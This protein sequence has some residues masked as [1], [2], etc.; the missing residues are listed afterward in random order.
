MSFLIKEAGILST[1]Q[2]LGRYGHQSTGISPSGALDY[3]STILANQLVG[4]QIDE[5]VVEMTLSGMTF[6]VLKDTTIGMAGAEMKIVVNGVNYPIGRPIPVAKGDI[7]KLGRMTKGLRTY[8]AVSGGI[9][10]DKELGSYATHTRTNMGG[11]KGRALQVGDR[12]QYNGNNNQTL[13]YYLTDLLDMNSNTI[14]IIPGPN[15]DDL[16]TISKEALISQPYK[17][18]RSN[19]RMGIRLDGFALKTADGVHDIL[20]E[21]TQL[22]NVQVPKNGQPIILLNDRQT[23]GGYKRIASV[24]KIDLPK[25][26]QMKPDDDI[27]FEMIT[28]EVATDLYRDEMK[29]LM[30]KEYLEQDTAHQYYRRVKSERIEKLMMG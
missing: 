16:T 26:V 19:D 11:Y 3:K 12:L 27:H 22:G 28:L 25:L 14:R 9:K 18:T 13:P 6:D 20:S 17:I 1:I 29:K 21:P 30:N 15:Y 8:L 23:T 10:I 2:D 7:V 5:A 4:N 24:A